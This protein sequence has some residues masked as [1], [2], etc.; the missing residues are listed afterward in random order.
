M[1]HLKKFGN[2]LAKYLTPKVHKILSEE[3]ENDR[4]FPKHTKLAKINSERLMKFEVPSLKLTASEYGL[5]ALSGP[6]IGIRKKIIVV[7]SKLVP[8]QWA[9]YQSA[10]EDYKVIIN[11]ILLETTREKEKK[12]EICPCLPYFSYEVER[13]IAVIIEYTDIQGT[14]KQETF[15]EFEARVLQHELHHL[16]NLY[17]STLGVSEG[18]FRTKIGELNYK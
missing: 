3:Y 5:G 6:V 14:V 4:I 7:Y 16:E 10:P 17:I 11:P 9:D 12:Y 8:D 2:T 18:K 15:Y 13:S 1:T